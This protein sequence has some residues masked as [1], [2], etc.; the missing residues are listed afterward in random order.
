MDT[1][2]L[3]LNLLQVFDALMEE[4]NLTRGG[5]RLGLSQPAMSHALDKLRKLTGDPLFV[6]VPTGMEPTELAN[7]IAPAVRDGLQ[8]LTGALTAHGTFDPATCRKTFHVLLSDIGEVV[9]L[10]RL[11]SRV[12]QEAPDV[13]V[14]VLQLPREAYQEALA[15][16]EA[17]LAIG[18]L[19]SLSTGIYQQRLYDDTHVCLVRSDHP[20]IR[21]TL[22]VDEFR[23]A[24]HV[25]VEPAGTRYRRPAT[26]TST[27]TLLEREL[28][29][30]GIARRIVLR[31]PHFIVVPSIVQQTELMATVP[32]Y[33]LDY[34]RSLENLTAYPAPFRTTP[35]SVRQ[36]WHERKNSDAALRWLRGLVAELFRRD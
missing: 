5:Y 11:I 19:P 2:K 8:L 16:G 3:D 29:E 17:D 30:Q 34:V 9:Y 32:S 33:V 13:Q 4:G 20:R 14:R 35:F 28:Q 21:G 26:Q 23:A 18:V 6:R 7:T 25:V 22:G 1:R 27:T 15:V 10:P 31:V 24:L 12:A 36:F